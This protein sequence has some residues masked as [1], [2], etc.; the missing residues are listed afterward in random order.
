MERVEKSQNE[1]PDNF[2]HDDE[3]NANTQPELNA[4]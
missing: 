1:I 2:R 3:P 4:Q